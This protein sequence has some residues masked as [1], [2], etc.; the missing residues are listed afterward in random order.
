MAKKNFSGGLESLLGGGTPKTEKPISENPVEL[1]PELM[2]EEKI[3]VSFPTKEE[4]MN[5]RDKLENTV[6]KKTK[7]KKNTQKNDNEDFVLNQKESAVQEQIDSASP[8]V[9]YLEA[10]LNT[11]RVGKLKKI[12]ERD[13]MSFE[14]VLKEAIDFY[15]DFQVELS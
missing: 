6:S 10:S 9:S 11:H 8:I 5:V 3:S 12:A 4:E 14:E 15:L 13:K 1:I 7:T 2:E